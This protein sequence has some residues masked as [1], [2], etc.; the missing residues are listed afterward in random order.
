M[1]F[2][3]TIST[4]PNTV[5]YEGGQSYQKSAVE[6]WMNFLFSSY[7]EDRFYEDGLI[8]TNRFIDLTN[9]M[10][11][12]Y[13]A[14]FVAKAALFARNELGMRSASQ[15]TAALLNAEKFADKRAFFRN[16]PH[17]ADDPAEIFAAI[18]FI[19]DKRSH[20]AVR[21]FGDYISSLS[22]YALGKYKLNNHEYNM[23][24]IINITHA[25]SDAIDAYKAGTLESPDTWEVA[26]SGAKDEHSRNEEWIRLVEEHKLGYLALIRNLRNILNSGVENDWIEKYLYPQ[27]KDEAAIHKSM[28]FPYQIY[29]AYKNMENHN[30]FVVLGLEK[31]FHIAIDNMPKLEGNTVIMLDVSGSMDSRISAKSDITIKEAGAVYAACILLTSEN[32]DIIKFGTTAAKYGFKKNDNIFDQIK[33]MQNNDGL[34]YGTNIGPAYSLINDKY[35]RIILI[36]DM[37]IMN[38]SNRWAYWDDTKEGPTCYQTYCKQYGRT[39]IYSFDLGNYATQTDNPNNPDVYLFTSLSEKILKFISLLEDGENLVDYINENYDYR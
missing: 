11:E 8:Q 27:L 14:E 24:D 15:L 6:D 36:S 33:R 35:D 1:R 21:G 16:Y 19:G 34:G 7:L 17:R 39:P 20:A 5:S 29:S 2:N 25:H 18:D 9:R 22:P 23:F 13:G 26:I 31:A 4:K 12:N 28:V 32:S 3:S 10:I 30:P 37:Q 38:N